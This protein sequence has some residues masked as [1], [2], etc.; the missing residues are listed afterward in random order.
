MVSYPYPKRGRDKKKR[1][2]T[3]IYKYHLLH[4]KDFLDLGDI[5]KDEFRDNIQSMD[6]I[7]NGDYRKL[8]KR[9]SVIIKL[10]QNQEIRKAREEQVW[11]DISIKMNEVMCL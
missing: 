4:N 8:T 11:K 2:L 9:L 10:P 3:P 7:R 5:D 1:N 6:S